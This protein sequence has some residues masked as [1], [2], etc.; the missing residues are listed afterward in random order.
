MRA[1]NHRP[2]ISRLS[3]ENFKSLKKFSVQLA[4]FTALVGPNGSGKS[5]ILGALDLI[6]EYATDP[7][8][9]T[10]VLAGDMSI[11]SGANHQ[12]DPEVGFKIQV[13]G[14]IGNSADGPR[15]YLYR[16]GLSAGRGSYWHLADEFL[17]VAT[18]SGRQTLLEFPSQKGTI[19]FYHDDGTPWFGFGVG[20][21]SEMRTIAQQTER[22]SLTEF[23]EEVLNWHFLSPSP[24]SSRGA[25]DA[26]R[27]V[28]LDSTGENISGV[29][30]SIYTEDRDQFDRIVEAVK[31]AI[32]EI[33]RIHT[34][35]T[36]E[37]KTFV[38]VKERGVPGE[39]P[40]WGLSDGTISLITIFTL[41]E[42]RHG[43]RL[44]CIEEPE[45]FVHPKIMENL[46]ESMRRAS[47]DCQVLISTHSPY[48]LNLLQPNEVVVVEKSSGA[49][50]ARA[51]ED[52]FGV[53]EAA[54]QLGLGEL[55]VSGGLGESP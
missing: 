55:W 49:T 14:G 43:P 39:L 3:A 12:R 44:I 54:K 45:N 10:N 24:S 8:R 40:I 34:P 51:A 22:N 27:D 1:P 28:R 13:D 26:K 35:T 25:S 17:S 16:L 38:S 31:A 37:G 30:H 36:S 47:K 53:A 9:V 23:A 5:S 21:Q 4:P 7:A 19:Q 6:Y 11:L 48:L 41:L 42:L 15:E 46:V 18:P 2:M 32:P 50:S 29:L 52:A 33:E 20:G